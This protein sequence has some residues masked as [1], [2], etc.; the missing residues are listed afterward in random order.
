L[1]SI[2]IFESCKRACQ[3]R[4]FGL[5]LVLALNGFSVKIGT[6]MEA[7]YQAQRSEWKEL[8]EYCL[9]DSRLTYLISTRKRIAVPEGFQWRKRNGGR[10]HDPENVL[11]M[12]IGPNREISFERGTLDQL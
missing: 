12:N 2:D 6:G 5:N 10:T 11:F 7:I 3:G 9:E 4:T 8:G 1:K